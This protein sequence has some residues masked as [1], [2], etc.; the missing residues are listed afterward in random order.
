MSRKLDDLCRAGIVDQTFDGLGYLLTLT[1]EGVGV[2]DH[3]YAIEDL[4]C[5]GQR[6]P[7]S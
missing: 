7:Y 3:L 1:N 2:A 4:L 6:I 5:Q